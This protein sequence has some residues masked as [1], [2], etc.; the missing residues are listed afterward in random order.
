MGPGAAQP[1]TSPS[2]LPVPVSDDPV[3][4]VLLGLLTASEEA[5]A[6]LRGLRGVDPGT[7]IAGM[8]PEVLASVVALTA[9][10][11]A[12]DIAHVASVVG[13][14]GR[15]VTGMQTALLREVATRGPRGERPALVKE[16]GYSSAGLFAEQVFGLR[17]GQAKDAVRLAEATAP[18]DGYS[19]GV[20][21]PK[22]MVLAQ[23]TD[24]G[25]IS[26]DQA[27][28]VL[29]GL[30]AHT[31]ADVNPEVLAVAEASLVGAASDGA[32]GI[33]PEEHTEPRNTPNIPGTPDNTDGPDAGVGSNPGTGVGAGV[34]IPQDAA[35]AREAILA[36]LGRD[37]AGL[38]NDPRVVWPVGSGLGAPEASRYRPQLLDVMAKTWAKIADQ[39]GA[40]PR[41]REHHRKRSLLLTHQRD[42]MWKIVILAPEVEGAQLKTVLDAITPPPSQYAF[43]PN[44]T[45]GVSGSGGNG[46]SANNTDDPAHH[47]NARDEAGEALLPGLRTEELPEL[48]EPAPVEVAFEA[49][50]R[51]QAAFDAFMSVI[52]HYAR[53]PKAPTVHEHAPTLLTIF[54]ETA[55]NATTTD[56][57]AGAGSSNAPGAEGQLGDRADADSA[58]PADRGPSR[59][60]AS[61]TTGVRG[62]G[63]PPP[64]WGAV[65]ADPI[66]ET[67]KTKAWLP[68]TNAYVPLSSI[69]RYFC[70]A[71]VRALATDQAGAALKLG[72]SQYPFNKHQ[73]LVLIARDRHCR[74]PGCTMPAGYCEAHHLIPYDSGGPTDIN[75][76]ILLCT[77]HHHLA[78]THHS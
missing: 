44:T 64:R 2:P 32:V 3:V 61:T 36:S 23:A 58:Y 40:E 46:R 34:L 18:R 56:N 65:S 35:T 27:T 31:G 72:H 47:D 25:E 12:K 33:A 9:S 74:A 11:S 69:A 67:M 19:Q 63:D 59:A 55:L 1:A 38:A 54:T 22:F 53:S 70:D 7:D 57:T 66:T 60:D 68:A 43:A 28:P 39:D 15:T 5:T 49:R 29:T 42:G 20:L 75:N 17:F 62:W 24:A 6:A 52:G 73:R 45:T 10:M 13:R 48:P 21:P 16:L 30:P 37:G 14:L 76:A 8:D 77:F 41:E 71:S 4:E 26:V 78:H 50:T 51:D